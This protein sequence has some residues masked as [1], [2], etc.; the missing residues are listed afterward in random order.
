MWPDAVGK[1]AIV[2]VMKMFATTAL[3]PKSVQPKKRATKMRGYLNVRV[4]QNVCSY[5]SMH[6]CH[7]YDIFYCK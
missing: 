6:D 4:L 3:L 1:F 2:V 7:I 5:F